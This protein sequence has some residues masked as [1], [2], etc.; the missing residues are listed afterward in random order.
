MPNA[1]AWPFLDEI[2]TASAGLQVKLLRF[3]QSHEFEAVGSNKTETVDVRVILATN[4]DLEEEV[5]AGRFRED[6]YYRVNVVNIEMPALADRVGD[7][8]SG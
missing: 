6:L 2:S 1:M 4:V 3:L 8:P 7:I 5:R